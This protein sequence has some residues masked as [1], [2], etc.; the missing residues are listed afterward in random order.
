[1]FIGK[2]AVSEVEGHSKVISKMTSGLEVNLQN[3]KHLPDMRKN[4]VSETMLR[5]NKIAM[6]READ[7]LMIRNNKIYLG[8]GYVKEGLVKMNVMIVTL[9]VAVKVSMNKKKLIF[10]FVDSFSI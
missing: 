3:M 6:T 8:K 1:M 7:K 10:Y 5:R 9:Y 4:L 2:T